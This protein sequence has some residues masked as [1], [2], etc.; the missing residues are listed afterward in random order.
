M[1]DNWMHDRFESAAMA[2]PRLVFSA[3]VGLWVVHVLIQG[4]A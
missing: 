2:R 4:F 1:T 3:I